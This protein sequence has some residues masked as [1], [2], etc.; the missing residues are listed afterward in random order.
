MVKAWQAMAAQNKG[1]KAGMDQLTK[2]RALMDRGDKPPPGRFDAY[3]V[4]FGR[5]WCLTTS[6]IAQM[7]VQLEAKLKDLGEDNN[8]DQGMFSGGLKPDGRRWIAKRT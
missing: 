3:A 1:N 8:I 5:E 2:I 6:M 4:M 7:F